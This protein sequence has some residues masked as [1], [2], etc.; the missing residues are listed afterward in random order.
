[1][2][3]PDFKLERYFA[4]YE[5]SSPYLLC[6]SDCES[7]SAGEILEMEPGGMEKFNDLRLGY[8]ESKG[9]PALRKEIALLYDGIDP[10]QVLVHTGAQEA[11]FIFMNAALQKGDHV[12]VHWPCYQS[13]AEV[14]TSIGCDVTRWEAGEENQWELDVDFLKANIRE[15][16][17]AVVINCPHNPTGYIMPREYFSEVNRLSREHGFI[18]FSDEV[19]RFLE[20]DEKD[21]V[22]SFCD[23]NDRAVSLGVMSKTFGL[24]GLRIGWIATRNKAVYDKMACFKDYTTICNSAPGEFLSCLS[25]RYREQLINRNRKIIAGNLEILNRFFEKYRDIFNWHM[26]KAGPVGFPSLKGRENA[27][28]FCENLVRQAGVLL[29]PGTVYGPLYKKNFRIGFGRKNLPEGI[30]QL[31]QYLDSNLR[32]IVK[33]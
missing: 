7:F 19:Y 11:I 3:V 17:K 32:E 31:E 20:Y 4:R 30:Q 8:T 10:D 25:L 1:M 23:V 24:A 15:N 13:L 27:E 6:C 28:E 12:I 22:P 14:A 33:G 21:R 2:Q 18:V 9:D 29:M 26:P 16:T 5:F